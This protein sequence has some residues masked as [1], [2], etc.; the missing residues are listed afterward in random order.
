MKMFIVTASL[1]AFC[2][3]AYAQT[4]SIGIYKVDNAGISRIEAALRKIGPAKMVNGK[5]VYTSNHLPVMVPLESAITSYWARYSWATY[6]ADLD[7]PKDT[8]SEALGHVHGS[9]ITGVYIKFSRDKIA[10]LAL[11]S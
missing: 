9:K 4:D 1:S 6:A 5:P 10:A 11:T 2:A 3:C 7:I 8:I